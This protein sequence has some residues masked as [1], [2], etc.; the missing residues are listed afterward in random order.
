VLPANRDADLGRP[1]GEH[2]IVLTP[3]EAA[4]LGDERSGPVEPVLKRR[5]FRPGHEDHLAVLAAGLPVGT[6]EH[7][8]VVVLAAELLSGELRV[9]GAADEE[10]G[11]RFARNGADCA[12][13]SGVVPDVAGDGR[14]RPDDERRSMRG[15]LPRR[16]AVLS[17]V[18]CR[19]AASHLR[20]WGMLPWTT[21]ILVVSGVGRR[22]RTTTPW[23]KIAI[24]SD[25]AI[26]LAR[27]IPSH[28]EARR[29]CRIASVIA[30]LTKTMRN[31]KP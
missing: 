3:N 18:A 7:H 1:H 20:S 22:A 25:A 9:L 11:T 24:S 30:A 27:G 23:T 13:E 4:D 16:R 31:D 26:R 10:M 5:I 28:I 12:A 17:S 2:S 29:P 14:L 8:A 19:N 21:A 15:G 6:E